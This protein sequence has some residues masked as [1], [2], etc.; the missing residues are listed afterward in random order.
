M[1]VCVW[2][3]ECV[4]VRALGYLSVH[5]IRVIQLRLQ[6]CRAY[7]YKVSRVRISELLFGI[8]N[9]ASG[10]DIFFRFGEK[11]ASIDVT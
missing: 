10:T 6:D 1:S 8:E 3:C 4:R 2:V 9:L 5:R 7:T 11:L